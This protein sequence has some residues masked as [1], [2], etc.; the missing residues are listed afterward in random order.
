[1]SAP[2]TTAAPGNHDV[3]SIRQQDIL[4]LRR[5][6]L[7]DSLSNMGFPAEWAHRAAEHC[8]ASVSESAAISWIIERS[9]KSVCHKRLAH[10]SQTIFCS[11][12]LR[13]DLEQAKLEEFDNDSR[14]HH[15]KSFLISTI[16]FCK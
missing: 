14:F 8:E 16:F 6:A 12:V 7:M 13:M 3:A 2:L 1:M 4:E 15:M 9:L 10:S 11:S 5:Q